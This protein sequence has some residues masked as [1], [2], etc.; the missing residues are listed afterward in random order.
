VTVD[1][2]E[3]AGLSAS[4]PPRHLDSACRQF[5]DLLI[6]LRAEG[7]GAQTVVG[8]EAALAPFARADG[9]EGCQVREHVRDLLLRLEV[10]G[11]AAPDRTPTELGFERSGSSVI[12]DAVADVMRH[13]HA[14]G[15][16]FR[17]TVIAEDLDDRS[18]GHV[19]TVSINMARLGYLYSGDRTV[20]FTRLDDL[21]EVARDTLERRRRFVQQLIDGGVF[22]LSRRLGGTLDGHV[23]AIGLAG[24]SRIVREMTGDR[25]DLSDP[26][27]RDLGV[28]VLTHVRDKV[29]SFPADAGGPFLLEVTTS[30]LVRDRLED[31]DRAR[32]PTPVASEAGDGTDEAASLL[33]TLV[34]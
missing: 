15:R 1:P 25:A 18:M 13:A 24:L 26:R 6:L 5:A 27:G 17:H 3:I 12:R 7:S 19:G 2:G 14:G 16:P 4:G 34:G 10:Y 30:R 33:K 9:L 22:P 28:Q 23:C 20:L 29:G 11:R 8:V 21:I 32:F 31:E